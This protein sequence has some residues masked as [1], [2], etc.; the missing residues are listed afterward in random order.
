MGLHDLSFPTFYLAQASRKYVVHHVDK[1]RVK[2]FEQPSSP[3]PEEPEPVSCV[4]QGDDIQALAIKLED[5][6]KLRTAHPLPEE[7]PTVTKKFLIRR[8]R[9]QEV[10]KK[11]QFLVAYPAVTDESEK[12]L[13]YSGVEGPIVDID[14]HI[15]PH[16]ILGTLQ[17]F[18]QEALARGHSQVAR[19]VPDA[20]P[21]SNIASVFEKSREKHVEER[22]ATQPLSSQ[23]M[24]LANWQHNMALRKK[25]QKK[26]CKHLHKSESELLM[27]FSD[28]Y[29]KI[30]EERTLIERSLCTLYSGKYYCTGNE[31]WTEP[32]HIGDELTG[33]TVTLGLN[34]LGYLEEVTHVGK[35]RSIYMEMG[36]RPAKFPPFYRTWEKS[37][38]LM[39]RRKELKEVLEKM[40][41]HRP[42]LD[43]LEVI[44]RNH[45]FV[46]V[47]TQSFS[48][49]DE[50][51]ASVVQKASKDQLE[52]Y[53]DVFSDHVLGPS[54]NFCGEPA[55]WINTT[56][57]EGEVG[58]AAR[59]TFEILV[60]EKAESCLTVSNDG[61]V[62][63]WYDWKRQP[64]P[65]TFPERKR[66]RVQN[67]YFNTRSGVILPGETKKFSFI[68]KSMDAG[69]FSES[70]QFGTH[71]RLLGGAVLQVTLWGVAVYED[72]TFEHRE[73]L[74]KELEDREVAVI[75]EENLK[76]LLD[77][78]RTPPQIPSPRDAYVTEEE[79][80][81]RKNPEILTTSFNKSRRY[82]K[83]LNQFILPL[84]MKKLHYQHQ[85]VKELHDLWNKLMNPPPT[86]APPP[87]MYEGQRRSIGPEELSPP[88]SAVESQQKSI[89]EETVEGGRRGRRKS[90]NR[91]GQ[92]TRKSIVEELIG[93]MNVTVV[94][95]VDRVEWNLSIMD[96]KKSVLEMPVE[97][98]REFG[99]AQ[100]NK[101]V[102]E[103]CTVQ[104]P[105]QLDLQ[106]QIC[107]QLWCE[108]IDGLVSHSLVLRSL[109]GMPEKDTYVEIVPEEPVEVKPVSVKGGKEDRR[110]QREEKKAAVKEKEKGKAVKEERPN[111]R[112]TKG[113]EEK[114]VKSSIKEPKEL[115][116]FS[117]D[118]PEELPEPH[119]EQVDPVVQEKYHEKLYVEVYGLLNSMVNKMVF[120]FEQLKKDAQEEK[121]KAP[122]V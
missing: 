114:K 95:D 65:F 74:Q 21:L 90:S 103:L 105:T 83:S 38:F 111:S 44:S 31:F 55:R 70:W 106:Y 113:K 68:F 49:Y 73:E 119:Q 27:N 36:T 93:P 122:F 26:L 33:L 54:L 29:R 28:N 121:N 118:A 77:R 43:G 107:F 40:D 30:Q 58:I 8:P 34:E 59:V 62:A 19:L 89:V 41:F 5:L 9:P 110:L 72:I 108:V 79:I 4:L 66:K 37:L 35:P 42:D 76:D 14:G 51:K 120:L 48:P 109:L 47:S 22:K 39:Q 91:I 116:A 17:E 20:P 94:K 63:I 32:V 15:I 75:V 87:C 10:G 81:H 99:L 53:P 50:D 46:S 64:Q 117:A 69:I 115:L 112:K 88:K 2:T 24:A 82:S 100:L 45:P 96:F 86:P 52:E 71:P 61:T 98:S 67:F 85:V 56:S 57:H 78:I 97:E 80:F 13:H 84:Y 18:K 25:Q 7:K 12:S 1:K 6:G 102:L 104:M 3:V 60:G 23:H 101:A 16:S 11:A 92:G